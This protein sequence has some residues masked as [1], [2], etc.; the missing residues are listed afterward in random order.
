MENIVE[1][2]S[3]NQSETPILTNIPKSKD[4]KKLFYILLCLFLITTSSLTTLLITKNKTAPPKSTPTITTIPTI[5][6]TIIEKNKSNFLNISDIEIEFPEGWVVS[7]VS[8]N[9]AKILTDFKPYNVYLLLNLEK[10]TATANSNY[11]EKTTMTK[12][13]YGTVYIVEQG[14]A[15]SVTGAL[16]NRNKYS[17]AWSIESNQPV[18]K[19]L[20]QIWS[21][22]HNITPEILFSITKTAKPVSVTSNETH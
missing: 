10:N 5:V 18:P 11:Q 3:P 4:F 8:E 1:S 19:N 22:D 16:I 20:D 7:S 2:S 21:P 13:E 6:P 14:G 17:F 15:M 12:T 9:T